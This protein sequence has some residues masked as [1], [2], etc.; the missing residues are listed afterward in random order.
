[1]SQEQAT[2]ES[3]GGSSRVEERGSRSQRRTHSSS[4]FIVDS[5]LPR[6]KSF[7]TSTQHSRRAEP[8]PQGKRET[9]ETETAPKKRSRFPWSRHREFAKEPDTISQEVIDDKDATGSARSPA[10]TTVPETHGESSSSH[11]GRRGGSREDQAAAAGLDR[12]S[13]QIVNL[14]LNLSESRKRGNAGYNASN[15]ISSGGTWA[16]SADGRASAAGSIPSHDSYSGHDASQAIRD[17]R[18]KSLRSP[19][20]STLSNDVLNSLPKSATSDSVPQG[21]SAGTMARAA[22]ARRHFEL[23]HEYLRLLPSLPPLRP[24]GIISTPDSSRE[25]DDRYPQHRGYNPLQA[26]R[27]RK[28]R[29]RERCP[30]DTEAKGWNDIDKVHGWVNSVE[31]GYSHQARSPLECLKLPPFQQEHNDLLLN[32]GVDVVDTSAISP[33]SSLRRISRTG[34]LKSRRPRSDWVIDPDELLADASWVEEAQNKSRLVDKD[35]NS[36]Y[37]NPASLV[38]ND[39]HQ[40][41][42]QGNRSVSTGRPS[43]HTSH[44][45]ARRSPSIDMNGFGRGRLP[46]RLRAPQRIGRSSSTSGQD[47]GSKKWKHRTRPRSSSSSSTDGRPY[48]ASFMSN[49][50]S[51]RRSVSLRRKGTIWSEKRGS[52]SSVPSADDRYDPLSLAKMEG[53]GSNPAINAGFFPSIA[54]NLS[55]P[56]SRSP[57]PAKRGFSRAVGPWGAQSRSSFYRKGVD[58]DSSIDFETVLKDSVPLTEPASQT[59]IE[60]TPL[61]IKAATFHHPESQTRTSFHE[62]KDSAQHESKLRGIFK[63]PGKIA[64]KVGNEV[65]KMGDFILKKDGV[66]HSRKSSLAVSDESDFEDEETKSEKRAIPRALLRRLPTFHDD[67]SRSSPRNSEKSLAKNNTQTP[68]IIVEPRHT[69]DDSEL[70][71]ASPCGS[72]GRLLDLQSDASNARSPYQGKSPGAFMTRGLRPLQFGP[73]IHTVRDEIRKGR[74]TDASVPYSM[75]RPPMTCLAQAQPTPESSSHDLRPP[76]SSQTRSWSIS[77]RSISISIESGVPGKQEIERTRALLLSSGIKAREI[78]RRAETVRNPPA[79]FLQRSV[80]P[81]SSIPPVPRLYEHELASRR[82]VK[83]IEASHSSFQDS[84]ERVPKAAFQ[85]L[86]SQLSTL[87]DLVNKSLNFR[88]RAAAEEAENLSIQLNTTSTLAVKQLSE[89]LD[90]GLRKRHRRLRWLRRT[91]FLMLEWALIGL[92]WWV[93]MIV[94]AFKLLRKLLYGMVSGVRWIL[95]L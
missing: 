68:P 92:L 33:P 76:L 66:A 70:G 77:N 81:D 46:R 12:D 20:V 58:D 37:P 36:L 18:G 56:S 44:S 86:K 57:S 88:V 21:F 30:I 32:K 5:F 14:A 75:V 17:D 48:H 19:V 84:I 6:S 62:R 54:S 89:T 64:G 80:A 85:P 95:W 40:K 74:I 61:P 45:D 4:G 34:S 9:S 38:V 3:L 26:I 52:L 83:R 8:D 28:V 29:L 51:P 41:Q 79:E 16:S 13:L 49:T 65:S 90:H 24:N 11:T 10:D 43:S 7:R 15:R 55:P 59:D 27:N 35:G 93:W 23:R 22:N 71:T 31:A 25:P 1:M 78:A 60:P 94:V 53:R 50:R 63:G 82:L 39:A 87:E 67:P 72:Q 42:V 73:E 91:G 2:R 47:L 69:R